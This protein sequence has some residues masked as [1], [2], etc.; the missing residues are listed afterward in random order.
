M[1]ADAVVLVDDAIVFRRSTGR[2]VLFA[3]IEPQ[4]LP[5]VF[6]VLLEEE[7]EE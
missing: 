3:V 4:S 2:R 6:R 7:G 5:C 1:R